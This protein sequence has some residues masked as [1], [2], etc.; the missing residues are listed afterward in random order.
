MAAPSSSPDNTDPAPG[1]DPAPA[2][3]QSRSS[4]LVL[5]AVA[6][7]ALALTMIGN[8]DTPDDSAPPPRVAQPRAA[9]PGASAQPA[10]EP[11]EEP[12]GKRLP[13]ATPLRLIIPEISVDAPFTTLAIGPNGQLE[14]PPADDVNLVGWHAKGASP[15]EPGTAIIAG[16]VDTAT[17]PA[18][19]ADLRELDEGDTFRVTRADRR[20]ATFVVDSVETFHKKN[21]P[22]RRVYADTPRA[23]V[24]LITCAGDYDRKVKDYMENLVVFAHLA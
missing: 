12:A 4:W 15:G 2:G 21:F 11:A 17:S 6:L 24:R 10:E 1:A 7:L 9:Q 16:H 14:P 22:D 23:Q 8:R 19:F 3:Q 5:C 20:T 13:R 18:V